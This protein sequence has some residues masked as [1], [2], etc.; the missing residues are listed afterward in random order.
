VTEHSIER[1]QV[2]PVLD[3]ALNVLSVENVTRVRYSLTGGGSVAFGWQ[4]FY[5]GGPSRSTVVASSEGDFFDLVDSAAPGDH[6]TLYDLDAVIT[7]AIAR[8]DTPTTV[9]ALGDAVSGF[10]AD[11]REVT[12]VL[13]AS[14]FVHMTELSEADAWDDDLA[15]W[16]SQPGSEVFLFDTTLGSPRNRLDADGNG[17]PIN[18]G[19]PEAGRRR[20]HA[21]I[22]A[23]HPDAD[24]SVPISRPH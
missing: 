7:L 11:G 22:D 2:Q 9:N 23:K 24:G 8:L 10:R 16:L 4:Y 3:D 17:Q 14:G 15:A 1:P 13:R 19:A 12:M 20:I 5:A 18:G 6:F 21:L